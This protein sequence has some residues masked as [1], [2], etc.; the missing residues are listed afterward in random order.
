MATPVPRG[1]NPPHPPTLSAL[2]SQ[3][4]TT[5]HLSRG[6]LEAPRGYLHAPWAY[7]SAFFSLFRVAWAISTGAP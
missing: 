1:E 5:L 7:L 6:Y 3:S 4:L 2:P